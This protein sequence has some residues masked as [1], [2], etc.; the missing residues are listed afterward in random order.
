MGNWLLGGLVALVIL[1]VV[2]MT[3]RAK[4]RGGGQLLDDSP[5]FYAAVR[6]AAGSASQSDPGAVG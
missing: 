2:L 5:E 3:L 1:I 4:R 6:P